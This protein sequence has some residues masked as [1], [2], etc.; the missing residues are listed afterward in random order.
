MIS[1]AIVEDQEEFSNVLVDYIKRYMKETHR[2]ITV[3]LFRDGASF[4]DEYNGKY[5]IVFM[6]IAMPHMNGLDAARKLRE[7]D[8]TV[9]LIFITS[10]AQYAIRGYEVSALDFILKPVQYD[11]FRI[12]LD[13][14]ISHIRKDTVF[15][16][17][18]PNG[19]KNVSLEDLIYIE[20]NKH[21]LYF[22]T[23]S[24]TYR[25]RGSMRELRGFFE[26]KGF[27][28]ANGS[29]LVNLSY[30]KEVHGNEIQIAGET[31]NIA[32]TYKTDFWNKLTVYMSGGI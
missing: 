22:R 23:T 20:S 31:L 7:K 9:C 12:K 6:D 5:Q 27:A 25:M 29:Q 15:T 11:L 14:A 1:I 4:I 21:Y 28:L 32:R 13:K 26:G 10:M 17:Q 8:N 30:V 2:T 18:I 19:V 24:D 16:I 3:S